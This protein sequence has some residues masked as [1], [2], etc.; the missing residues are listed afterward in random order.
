MIFGVTPLAQ[1]RTSIST[2]V[3]V[4]SRGE[5]GDIVPHLR[6]RLTT[7]AWEVG[8]IARVVDSLTQR[9]STEACV[10]GGERVGLAAGDQS[11]RVV[12]AV[13]SKQMVAAESTIIVGNPA[14]E[15]GSGSAIVAATCWPRAISG[16]SA[17]ST[18]SHASRRRIP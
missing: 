11:R 17:P 2:S 10:Q 14:R 1:R 18:L 5:R 4:P 16:R 6:I 12:S 9:Y 15:S 13:T 7:G 8:Q 3:C